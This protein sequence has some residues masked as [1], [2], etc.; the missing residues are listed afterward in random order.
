[1]SGRFYFRLGKGDLQKGLA[2]IERS[3]NDQSQ[4][5]DALLDLSRI[6]SG[7][8]RRWNVSAGE[9]RSQFGRFKPE[10]V[11]QPFWPCRQGRDIIG[12]IVFIDTIPPAAVWLFLGSAPS[13]GAAAGTPPSPLSNK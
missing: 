7:R 12:T 6:Q 3:A 2:Q 10:P 4:L 5:L 8:H 9:K 1:M 13:H 11:I